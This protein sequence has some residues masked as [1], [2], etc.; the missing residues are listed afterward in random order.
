MGSVPGKVGVESLGFI[1]YRFTF[2]S[3]PLRFKQWK[4]N[5]S[6]LPGIRKHKDHRRDQ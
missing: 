2:I 6:I 3:I 4:F 5:R 1:V